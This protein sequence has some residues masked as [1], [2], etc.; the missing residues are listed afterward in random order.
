MTKA[1]A[2]HVLE[3]PEKFHRI[4]TGE[5]TDSLA[6]DNLSGLTEKLVPLFDSWSNA[7]LEIKTKTDQISSLI[8]MYPKGKIVA[9]F[10]VNWEKICSQGRAA[11]CAFQ[12]EVGGCQGI[13]GTG[14]F[15]EFPF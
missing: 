13:A 11:G 14:I 1:L 7:S 10:S 12:I 3:N 2:S 15:R 8:K 9:G 6:L 5:F 4:C